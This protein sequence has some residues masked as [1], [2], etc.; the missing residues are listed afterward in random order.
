MPTYILRRLL[1]MIPTLLGAFT[2][3]F[4]LMRLLPGDVALYILGSG[5]SSEINKQA[6]EQIRKDLGLD[7][8]LSVQYV[9]WL[10][11]AVQLDFGNS[12]WTRQPV[13]DEL[14]RRYPITANLAVM[15]LLIGTCIAIPIGLLSAIR[16]DTLMDYAAR[17]FVIGG[18]SIP[19]FWLAILVILG[20]VR[21]FQWLPPLNVAPFWVD[22]LLNLQQ[23]IF[24]ALITG[25]RLSAI[26][27]R[28]TRS[29]VLEVLRD[30]FV[31]TARAKGLRESA[32]V[33]RHAL[34]NALLPVITIIGVELLTLF[35]G[36]VVIETVF[37]IPGIGR[38]L[39]DAITHRDYPSIQALIFVFAVFVV[40]VNLLVDLIY[41]VLDP[42]VRYA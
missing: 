19:N 9:Q 41:A 11:G 31:R 38:F 21:Y 10:W 30:D 39:V 20:L 18:L 14:K 16:Q 25:Y 15:S 29:S 26:G 33:I 13:V 5:E 37:T 40:L 35:G 12:Y 32:V 23:L 4:I 24:P 6:L 36:L 27:A 2:L 42:R 1:L 7:Q 22:P 3:I 28:M 17:V 34:R 8:P